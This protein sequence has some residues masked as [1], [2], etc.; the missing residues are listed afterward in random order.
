M[1]DVA[2]G[3][4]GQLL[5]RERNGEHLVGRI[6]E[7]EAYGGRIDPASHSYRG[8]TDRCR[9]M[10]G[11]VG[12]AYVYRIYGIHHCLNVIAGSRKLAGAV[13]IRAVEPVRGTETLR[14]IRAAAT[15]AGRTR[16]GLREGHLDREI[17]SG[18]GKLAA[19]FALDGRW[20]GRDLTR[21]SGLRIARG[22]RVDRVLWTPRI[23]LGDNPA[24]AWRWR[25]VDPESRS[26][27]R[28]PRSWPT[29][30]DPDPSW[31]EVR[32]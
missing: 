3:L 17:A 26:L 31:K 22:Q 24:A 8:P 14:A 4:L 30:D 1:L 20:N 2:R 18:P 7:T 25:C 11:P 32:V 19:A 10:F 16:D 29:S 13:L 6:V 5:V 12:R 27:T 23:G 9:V 15:R 28:V 21:S